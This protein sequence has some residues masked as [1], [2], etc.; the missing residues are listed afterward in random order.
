MRNWTVVTALGFIVVCLTPFIQAGCVGCDEAPPP[1]QG[2][3]PG[4]ITLYQAWNADIELLEP[5]LLEFIDEGVSYEAEGGDDCYRIMDL[6]PCDS[7]A[8]CLWDIDPTGIPSITHAEII[9]YPVTLVEEAMM[10]SD[11]MEVFDSSYN[12]FE[13]VWEEGREAYLSGEGHFYERTYEAK[14]A[15]LTSEIAIV[16]NLQYRRID[17]WDG[18]GEPLVL[19]R[20]YYPEEPLTNSEGITSTMMFSYEALL[21]WDDGATTMRVFATWSDLTIGGYGTDDSWGLACSQSKSSW[22]DLRNWCEEN[23]G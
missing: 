17:D 18:T 1:P 10:I 7:A 2:D 6:G 20:G 5:L 11:W 4:D 3:P 19:I 22:K 9:E 16:T 15:I 13:T 14:L 21:P 12:T 8:V 23:S